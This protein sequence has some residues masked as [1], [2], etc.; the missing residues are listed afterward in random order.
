MDMLFA[1]GP[2]VNSMRNFYISSPPTATQ[3]TAM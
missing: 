3:S 1:E 2:G